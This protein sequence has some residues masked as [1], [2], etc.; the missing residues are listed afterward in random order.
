MTSFF[1]AA[2]TVNS[3]GTPRRP[4]LSPRVA[5]DHARIRWIICA[6]ALTLAPTC[7]LGCPLEAGTSFC[8]QS[9]HLKFRS[10]MVL[11]ALQRPTHSFSHTRST[12]HT[13]HTTTSD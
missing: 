13:V 4:V 2:A 9:G 12:L 11:W 7:V 10:G 1:A 3:S 5:V 6:R 8:G